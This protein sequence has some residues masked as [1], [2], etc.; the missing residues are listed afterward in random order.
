MS[1]IVVIANKT[2]DM[3]AVVESGLLSRRDCRLYLA[4]SDAAPECR[5]MGIPFRLMDELHRFEDIDRICRTAHTITSDWWKSAEL[6]KLLP[7][8]ES[9]HGVCIGKMLELHLYHFIAVAVRSI[10][11]AQRL[12]REEKPD[13]VVIVDHARTPEAGFWAGFYFEAKTHAAEI[14]FHDRMVGIPPS[15]PVVATEEE[16]D[17]SPG[18]LN[19]G[20]DRHSFSRVEPDFV[21]RREDHDGPARILIYGE[22]RHAETM[23][24]LLREIVRHGDFQL[25]VLTQD[26]PESCVSALQGEGATIVNPEQWWTD[27]ESGRM[28]RDLGSAGSRWRSASKAKTL[29][30]MGKSE[31]GVSIWPIVQFEFDWVFESGMIEIFKRIIL[32]KNTVERVRP[33]LLLTSVDTS[34]AD[35]SWIFAAQSVGIPCLTQLHGTIYHIPS[36]I[37]WGKCY[38]E[39]LAVW[40]PMTRDWYVEMTGRSPEDFRPVGYPQFETIRSNYESAN[41]EEVYRLTGFNRDWPIILFLVSMTGGAQGSYFASQWKIYEAFFSEMAKASR[42]QLVVRTHPVSNP[43]IA[44]YFAGQLPLPCVVNPPVDLLP[45]LKVA[46]LVVGQPTTALL[47]AMLAGKPV[48]PYHVGMSE[49]FAWW[50]KEELFPIV[51]QPSHLL[52]LIGSILRDPMLRSAVVESQ[53]LFLQKAVGT[54]DGLSARRTIQLIQGMVAEERNRKRLGRADGVSGLRVGFSRHTG[55]GG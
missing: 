35:L 4:S 39:K 55:Q 22:G 32:A 51:K 47:D 19:T 16:V 43:Q 38:A 1:G 6:L 21:R 33:H 27:S 15:S 44:V 54:V 2:A 31:L 49:D 36:R 50:F 23:L 48:L 5:R 10:L 13:K 7:F 42:L 52:P 41:G 29:R 53:R 26:M 30:D 18:F 25:M 12:D 46:D 34:L 24:P 8:V 3:H 14:V 20:E 28:M 11:I 40:G 9:Y 37:M 45:L 17:F